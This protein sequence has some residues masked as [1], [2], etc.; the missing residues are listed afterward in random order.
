MNPENAVAVVHFPTET[1]VVHHV[2]AYGKSHNGEPMVL[3]HVPDESLDVWAYLD[4]V[5]IY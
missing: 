3:V 5:I 2:V 1:L 4:E